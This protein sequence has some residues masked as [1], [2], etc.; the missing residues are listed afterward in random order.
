MLF[1]YIGKELELKREET[2]RNYFYF[3]LENSNCTLGEAISVVLKYVKLVYHLL[4]SLFCLLFI[5]P[6]GC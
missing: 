2:V 6:V 1:I 4:I 5:K 3:Y